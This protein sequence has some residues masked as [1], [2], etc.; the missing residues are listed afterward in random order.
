MGAF[1][2]I[3][4]SILCMG[5]L[6]S[7]IFP[8]PETQFLNDNFFSYLLDEETDP[9]TNETYYSDL[10][11]NTKPQWSEGGNTESGFLQK[12]IDGLSVIKTFAITLVNIAVVPITIAIR[13]QM[14][15]AVRILLFIPLA[16]LY[17]L[18]FAMTIIRGVQP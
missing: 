14:P 15:V 3:F 4:I 5:V 10:N 13:M 8:G 11:S 9:L 17:I 1:F 18:S 6:L 16:V 12:F 7:L 2:K